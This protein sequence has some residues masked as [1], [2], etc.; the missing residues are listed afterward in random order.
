[1]YRQ[2]ASIPGLSGVL[3]VFA[4]SSFSCSSVGV[5]D[6]LSVIPYEGPMFTKEEVHD[7]WATVL[8]GGAITM[9]R[10]PHNVEEGA[11]SLVVTMEDNSG[12]L[13]TLIDVWEGPRTGGIGR[14][15]RKATVEIQFW[16]LPDSISG[17]VRAEHPD[18][19]IR[20]GSFWIESVGIEQ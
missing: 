15:L 14:R 16:A 6:D 10:I 8:E 11:H 12:Q 17:I 9:T 4:L 7:T 19:G 5:E 20:G 2:N 3:L 18:G 1:M 13:P